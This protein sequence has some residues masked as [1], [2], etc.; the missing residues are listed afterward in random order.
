MGIGAVVVDLEDAA[1]SQLLSAT[2]ECSHQS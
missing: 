1:G 2:R